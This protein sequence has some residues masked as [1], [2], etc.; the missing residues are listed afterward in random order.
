MKTKIIVRYKVPI[1]KEISFNVELSKLEEYLKDGLIFDKDDLSTTIQEYFEYE[2]D[3]R[4]QFYDS[5]PDFIDNTQ[6][7][8]VE[9]LKELIEKYSYL[10]KEK[11]ENICCI[12]NKGSNYCS[13][14]GKK[15]K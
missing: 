12:Q 5:E 4:T 1:Y 14:C 3:I 2:S 9:D 11:E 13:I 7:L 6:E 8:I 10:I 15:L